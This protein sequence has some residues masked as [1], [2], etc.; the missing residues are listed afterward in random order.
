MNVILKCEYE[1]GNIVPFAMCI[2]Y[3]YMKANFE[4]RLQR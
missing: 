1:Q 2:K 4:F 3:G